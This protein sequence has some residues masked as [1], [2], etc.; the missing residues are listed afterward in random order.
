MNI[1]KVNSLK[2][3]QWHHLIKKGNKQNIIS[4]ASGRPESKISS[5]AHK[6]LVQITKKII[7]YKNIFDYS[8]ASGI[9]SLK[10]EVLKKFVDVSNIDVLITNGAQQAIKL[11]IDAL[12]PLKGKIIIPNPT[13]LGIE[14]PLITK[15][16]NIFPLSLHTLSKQQ[17]EKAIKN[18][19]PHLLY[20]IPDFSNPDGKTL[21][22]EKRKL[23][24]FLAKKYHFFI[25]EDQTYRFLNYQSSLLPSIQSFDKKSTIS[26]G[27]ISKIIAPGLRIGWI[28]ASHSLIEK[29]TLYKEAEDLFTPS[30]NQL[31]VAEFLKDSKNFKN[32][33]KKIK[34]LY[35]KRLALLLKLLKQYLSNKFT[36]EN[37]KG[38]FYVWIQGSKKFKSQQY[39]HKAL[40]NNVAF[41]PGHIF[42]YKN[43]QYNNFRLSIS[44]LSKSQIKKGVKKLTKIIME[45]NKIP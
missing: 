40:K 34:K 8:S 28:N 9:P 25:I 18:I 22:L 24:A 14:L 3:K 30:L 6:K 44:A 10:Q 43:P 26:I 29:L 45:K 20:V 35:Q 15:K 32:H 4:F 42:Y 39:L 17:L 2:I 21:S 16:A 1:N 36:W 27:T 41:I 5:I 31:I 7:N 33:Q 19:R 23:L 37:P 13:Y 11:S 38:G 12:I